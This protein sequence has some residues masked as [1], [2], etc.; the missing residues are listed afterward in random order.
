MYIQSFDCTIAFVDGVASSLFGEKPLK[1]FVLCASLEVLLV[2][3]SPSWS[4]HA[5]CRTS[6]S[7]YSV[8]TLHISSKSG[9]WMVF[10][11]T[12]V[13]VQQD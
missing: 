2:T 3:Q 4:S 5:L 13:L 10:R 12:Y 11:V 8:Q 6:S 7:W 9:E 1:K